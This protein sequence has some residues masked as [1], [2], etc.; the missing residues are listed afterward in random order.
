MRGQGLG[1]GL[2]VSVCSSHDH[3]HG[4]DASGQHARHVRLHGADRQARLIAP[5]LTPKGP[6]GCTA[7]TANQQP[8]QGTREWPARTHGLAVSEQV[9]D[10][11]RSRVH[12]GAGE[13]ASE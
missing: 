3:H 8:T 6:P 10:G 2:A 9:K 7:A 1:G 5:P 12:S 13:G 4:A 11:L